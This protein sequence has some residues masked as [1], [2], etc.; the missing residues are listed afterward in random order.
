MKKRTTFY[1]FSPP[2]MMATFLIEIGLA[3]WTLWRYKHTRLVKLV[4]L[5][6]V[7]LAFFQLAEYNICESLFGLAGITWARLGYVAI[8]ALPALGIHMV[9]V[10]AGKKM[11]WLVAGSYAAMAVFMAYFLFSTQ[12]LTASTC[13]GNYVIFKTD[14]KA[15]SWYTLYYYGLELAALISAWSLGRSTKNPRKRHALYGVTAAYLMLI[16][17]VATVNIINPE[18]IHA[19]PSIMCGFAVFLALTVTLYVLPRSA[20]IRP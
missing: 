1:C 5:M 20:Q 6:L 4:V 10:L 11:P 7:C 16:L 9:T 18:L 13:G 12:G 19:V 2:V 3:A 17:P 15:T 14:N 8:T